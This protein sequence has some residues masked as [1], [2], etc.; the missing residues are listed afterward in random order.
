MKNTRFGYKIDDPRIYKGVIFTQHS[1]Y[2]ADT[3]DLAIRSIVCDKDRAALNEQ[4]VRL[5]R[6]HFHYKVTHRMYP[7]LAEALITSLRQVIGKEKFTPS[8]ENG[9]KEILSVITS[10]YMEGAFHEEFDHSEEGS[11]EES[12]LSAVQYSLSTEFHEELYA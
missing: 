11:D 2:I 4:L 6:K 5:G 7:I 8:V 3:L 12:H 1:K 10:C 9:Y